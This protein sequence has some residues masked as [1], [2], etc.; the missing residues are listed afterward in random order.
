[1]NKV[2]TRIV[3]YAQDIMNITGRCKRTARRMIAA[4]RKKFN[5]PTR[6]FITID[7]FCEFTGLTENYVVAYLR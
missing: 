1:M 5:K 6:G 3:L 4:M 2:P 7:D